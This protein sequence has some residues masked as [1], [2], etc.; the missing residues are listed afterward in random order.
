MA[1]Q[2]EKFHTD[3]LLYATKRP[4]VINDANLRQ[5][6][7]AGTLR[8]F[9]TNRMYF[10]I[11][12]T[13]VFPNAATV[14]F[15]ANNAAGR[16]SCYL[17]PYWP[18]GDV[19]ILLD[20][21]AEYFFTS[22][23]SGCGV[24]IQN[25]GAQLRAIHS[26]ARDLFDAQ[27]GGAA[28]ANAARTAINNRLQGYRAGAPAPVSRLTKADQEAAFNAAYAAGG[29]AAMAKPT[30]SH[31]RLVNVQIVNNAAALTGAFFGVN[32]GGWRFYSQ[33]SSDMTGTQRKFFGLGKTV[34]ID[35]YAMIVMGP[36]DQIWPDVTGNY[37]V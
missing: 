36:P 19:D 20:G 9:P 5:A 22:N 24:Q 29:L 23:L 14:T 26:N 30:Q 18:G 8:T 32:N 35:L 1:T 34:N 15:Y 2:T 16:R 21:N 37:T 12:I 17:L 10:E 27:G 33:V 7:P 25:Q 28:G 3:P 11:G 4:L 6:T 13:A 31:A